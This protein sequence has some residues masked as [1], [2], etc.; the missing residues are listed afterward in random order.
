[1]Q[2][3]PFARLGEAQPKPEPD[4]IEL[5]PNVNPVEFLL[6]IMRDRAQP[7]PRRIKAAEVAAPY[8]HAKL[9]VSVNIGVVGFAGRLERA[10]SARGLSPVI[11]ALPPE[12]L[13]PT[14]R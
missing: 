4:A 2:L 5:P 3:P 1:M 9:G 11:G 10:I 8:V 14:R 6:A 7:M 13:E 12:V